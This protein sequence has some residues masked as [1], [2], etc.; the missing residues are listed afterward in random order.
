MDRIGWTDDEMAPS[1]DLAETL[2]EGWTA[3]APGVFEFSLDHKAGDPLPGW[4]VPTDGDE[5]DK[6]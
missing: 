6:S 3:R 1:R 5:E 2:G 4:M